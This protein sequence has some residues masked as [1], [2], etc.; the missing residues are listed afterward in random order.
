MNSGPLSRRQFLQA[1]AYGGLAVALGRS[2]LDPLGRGRVSNAASAPS[3]PEIL[4]RAD[5]S[6]SS[7]YLTVD[8]WF[9]REM[10]ETALDIAARQRVGLTFF[11]IGRLVAGNADLVRRAARE[12]HEIENHTWDHQRLDLGHCPI[13]RIPGEIQEQFAALQKLLGPTYRQSFLRPPGGFGILGSVNPFLVQ[14]AGQAGLRIAMWSVDSQGWK[15]GRRSDPGAVAWSLG[16][17]APGL[18]DGAIVLEHAI[19]A[20]ILALESE[21][22]I[23][24]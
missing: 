7:V 22:V 2:P 21:I 5:R 23:A 9:D 4:W 1:S 11:P 17:V 20:D 18:G 8:D 19:P 16:N 12:G 13:A 24:K 15:A 14:A 10:V 6:I 3:G